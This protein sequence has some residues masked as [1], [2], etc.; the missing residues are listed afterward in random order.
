[1]RE[2]VGDCSVQA[3]RREI[4]AFEGEVLYKKLLRK[5]FCRPH[6]LHETLSTNR[7]EFS[8]VILPM[9]VAR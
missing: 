9:G 1:M 5:A 3:V 6:H 2:C 4:D 7:A 8:R